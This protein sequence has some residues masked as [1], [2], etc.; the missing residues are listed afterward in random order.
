MSRSEPGFGFGELRCREEALGEPGRSRVFR[1]ADERREGGEGVVLTYEWSTPEYDY[2]SRPWYRAGL[3]AG[4]R[5][6]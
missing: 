4:G 3:E 1:V 2:P 6:A 5:P